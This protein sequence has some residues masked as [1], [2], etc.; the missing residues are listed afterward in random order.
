MKKILV[1]L[2]GFTEEH[3]QRLAQVLLVGEG[4]GGEG[5]GGLPWDGAPLAPGLVEL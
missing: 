4:G 3:R 2:R 1:Y 5:E